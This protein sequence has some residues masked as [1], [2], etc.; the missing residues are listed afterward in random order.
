MQNKLVFALPLSDVFVAHYI[1]INHCGEQL[2]A[3]LLTMSFY[4]S[5]RSVAVK[6]YFTAWSLNHY[7]GGKN[8][9]KNSFMYEVNSIQM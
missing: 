5:T 6:S 9:D 4:N 3:D 1:N 2:I 7:Y 8:T